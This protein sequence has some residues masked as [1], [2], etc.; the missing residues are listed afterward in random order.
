MQTALNIER[1]LRDMPKGEIALSKK[2]GDMK[3][4][5]AVRLLDMNAIV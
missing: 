1:I 3:F 5:A 2:L 4:E